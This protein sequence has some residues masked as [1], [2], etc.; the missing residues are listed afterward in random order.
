DVI[1]EDITF[2]NTTAGFRIKTNNDRSGNDQEGTNGAVKNIICRNATMTGVPG[3]I[4]ITSWYDDDVQDPSTVST[5]SAITATTPEFCNIT[6]QNIT[7]DAVE[8]KT[9]WKHNS[10]IYIYGRPEMKI[11]DI[12]FDNV[13]IESKRGMFLAYYDGLNFINN[14]SVNATSGVAPV[15]TNYGEGTITG[16]YVA[17]N[18]T[19]VTTTK[20][21]EVGRTYT[22]AKPT[23]YTTSSTGA[24]TFA[25]SNDAVAT[26][27]ATTGEITAVAA[28]TATI[29]ISQAADATYNSGTADITVT[30]NPAV[31]T[32]T[33]TIFDAADEGW[34]A[35]GVNLTTGTTT[36]NGVTWYGRSGAEM[37]SNNLEFSDKVSW[38]KYLKTGGSSTFKSGSDLAGV[39][40]YTPTKAGKIRVY[41]KGGG[42][43]ER[44]LY[45]SQSITSTNRDAT[46]AIG[47]SVTGT[48]S[49]VGIAT[50]D[51]EA[52]KPVYIWATNSML[53]Y[54]ITFES[55]VEPTHT[56]DF[57][58]WS[59]ATKTQVLG[60]T[61]GWT[62]DEGA[63]DN[64]KYITGDQIR[65]A[66][67][68][69]VDADGNLTAGGQVIKELEGLHHTGVD[70]Y[71]LGLAFDYQNLLDGN[72]NNGWGPY[73]GGS[74]L[75]VMGNSTTITIPNVKKGS[76][77][78]IGVESHKYLPAD[79]ATSEA[80]GFQVLVGGTEVGETQ[81]T[82]EYTE[83]SYD[84]SGTSGVVD[85]VLK[86]TKGCHLYWIDAEQGE[87]EEPTPAPSYP[88]TATWDFKN[89]V[90]STITGV[91][92]QGKTEDVASDKD[93]INLA[94]DATVTDGKLQ[95]NASGYAQFNNGTIIHV[96]VTS[97]YDEINVVAFPGQNK[98]TIGG[99]AAAESQSYN[100]SDAEVTQEFVEIKATGGAY[101]YSI[102]VTQQ[103]AGYVPTVD[104]DPTWDSTNNR[105][106]VK[107]S[108]NADAAV[109][110][111]ENAKGLTEALKYIASQTNKTLYIPNGTYDLGTKAQTAVPA[112]ATLKGE[113]MEG[114]IIKNNP[115]Y[116]GIGITATLQID[117]DN[118][119]LED[120]TLYCRA[121]YG[122]TLK[123]GNPTSSNA[124]RG[125]CLVDRGTNN[126]FRHI[127]LDGLQDTYYSWKSNAANTSY[128]YDCVLKGSVD[129][130]CGS[131][132]V[133]FENCTLGVVPGHS[134][135]NG[136]L[137]KNAPYII[138]PN[139]DNPD[140]G[141]IF[142]NCTIVNGSS[143]NMDGN[144][145][146]GRPW[147]AHPKASFIN[148][149]MKILPK[150]DGFSMQSAGTGGYVASEWTEI[151]S[152]DGLGNPVN[153]NSRMSDVTV[154][155][156][157]KPEAQKLPAPEV[158]KSGSKITWTAVDGA[159]AYNV[160]KDGV[161][162]AKIDVPTSSAAKGMF[163]TLAAAASP[164]EYDITGAEDATWTVRAINAL[165]VIGLAQGEEPEVVDP[166]EDITFSDEAQVIKYTNKPFAYATANDR[167]NPAS[168]SA[169][170]ITGGGEYDLETIMQK[171]EADGGYTAGTTKQI[172]TSNGTKKAIVLRSA[173]T[174][175]TVDDKKKETRVPMDDA[176]FNAIKAN[177][178]IV[179]DGSG[180]ST[181]FV[182]SKYIQLSR[183]K[184]K[185]IVGINGARLCT[186]WY[187][188]DYFKSLLE[189]VPTSSG[190]G[191]NS[192]ST[193]SGGGALEIIKNGSPYVDN[194]PEEGEYLTR[195]TLLE[196]TG[197]KTEA[198]RNAGIFYIDHSSN[199][200]IRNFKFIGPGS[201]DCAG[202]D[203][204]AIIDDT[205]HCWV[206]HCEF[207]DGMDGNFDITNRSD[208]VT[209]SWCQFRYTERSYAHQNTNL[210]G[211]SDDKTDDRN[212]LN[213][214]FA[215]NE[216][217]ANCRARMPMARFGRIHMLNNYYNCAG[218]SEYA[219]N[220]RKESQFLVEGNYWEKG[221]RR[222]Y[223]PN[224]QTAVTWGDNNFY[225]DKAA[226]KAGE[227]TGST[228]TVP[229]QY[230][231][232]MLDPM[233]V[234]EV[235]TLNGGA[236]LYQKP[237]FTTNLGVVD[238]DKTAPY[239][240]TAVLSEC[241]DDGL[242]FSVWA[243]N[244]HTFQWYKQDIALDGTPGEWEMIE[245]ENRNTYTYM[246]KTGVTFNIKCKAFGV[247][248][249]TESDEL[250]VVV[251]GESKPI[252]ITDLDDTK[253]VEVISGSPKILT[254]NAGTNG[255]TYQ[256]YKSAN[257]D[258]SSATVI[259][260][261]TD[262]SYTYKSTAT[263]GEVVY[264]FCRATNQQ[265]YTDS[266]IV[267][268]KGIY[269]NVKFHMYATYDA[270]VVNSNGTTG[271]SS[272]FVDGGTSNINNVNS[273]TANITD[274]G[275]G[276][277]ATTSN[278]ND[279]SGLRFENAEGSTHTPIINVHVHFTPTTPVAIDD[280]IEIKMN[281][282][283]VSAPDNK[284]GF[285]LS[286]SA[287]IT[288]DEDANILQKIGIPTSVGKGLHTYTYTA[289]EAL[290]TFY[291][292]PFVD[293]TKKNINLANVVV[294][295]GET[296]KPID[297]PM[298][299]KNLDASYEVSQDGTLE[300]EVDYDDN[301]VSAVQWYK[302]NSNVAA[303]GTII[304]GEKGKKYSVPTS[305][306]GMT[307]YY[308]VI[309][310]KA[311]YNETKVASVSTK[312]VV[313]AKPAGTKVYTYDMGKYPGAT[314]SEQSS[315]T[316]ATADI[317]SLED[318]DGHKASMQTKST[319]QTKYKLEDKTFGDGFK[320]T[321]Y[322]RFDGGTANSGNYVK[323][324][325]D[326]DDSY[327]S[328]Y[329]K[330]ANTSRSAIVFT[331]LQSIPTE[332]DHSKALLFVPLGGASG[333]ID[334]YGTTEALK[335][336]T[337]YVGVTNSSYIYGIV[338]KEPADATAP[339]DIVH[340]K[341]ANDASLTKNTEY[342]A[343]LG[344][345]VFGNVS[346]TKV[347]PAEGDPF[348]GNKLDGDASATGTKYA[349]II[350][351]EGMPVKEGDIIKISG[352]QDKAET[353][354]GYGFSIYPTRAEGMT[355]AKAL[356][357][358]KTKNTLED[359]E[360]KV[361]SGSS[362]IDKTEFFVFREGNTVYLTE[363]TI[364][365]EMK[366]ETECSKPIAKKTTWNATA[367]ETWNYTISSST[368]TAVI[369]YQ[370]GSGEEVVASVAPKNSVNVALKPG[371]TVKAWATDS[372]SKIDDSEVNEFTVAAKPQTAKPTITVALYSIAKKG[373]DVTISGAAAGAKVYYT[374]DGT[375]PTDASTL[376][377]GVFTSP[378]DMTIKAIAIEDHYNNSDIA[379]ANIAKFDVAG[380]EDINV[381][382][383][384]A[385]NE[386]NVGV[387]Y[388]V[389]G[390]EYNAG[391]IETK[392]PTSGIKF[393]VN[394]TLAD[395][396]GKK[397]LGF[398]IKVNDGFVIN[399]IEAVDAY[400][401]AKESDKKGSATVKAAYVDVT[402][403]NYAGATSVLVKDNLTLPYSDKT[404]S[405]EL[406]TK[407]NINARTQVDFVCELSEGA[408]V[409]QAGILFKVYYEVIDAP[410]SV[411]INGA[412][413]SDT[414]YTTLT[415]AD[416]TVVLTK[417]YNGT[418]TIIMNTEKGY[419]HPMVNV[420]SDDAYRKYQ[421]TIMGT[422]YTV[423]AMVES[424]EAPF[425]TIAEEVSLAGGYKVTV[426]P[427]PTQNTVAMISID[428]GEY[429]VYD[430]KKTYYA[431]KT[432]D[433]KT[434]Y[435]KDEVEKFTDVRSLN[436]PTNS[437]TAG[438]P[439]A[440]YL[441]VNGYS[442]NQVGSHAYN[443]ESFK[444][445][446]IYS[447]IANQFNVIPLAV[448]NS[449][450]ILE[451][452]SDITDA[453]LVVI[454]E[455]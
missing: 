82:K 427:D 186:E 363:I 164:L 306:M 325:L 4:K 148:T 9:S 51:V 166:Y 119:T 356:S 27:N 151:G 54:G 425:A 335:K 354:S 419:E 413:L 281:T 383:G 215:Y 270:N 122:T 394:R 8:G 207:V 199:L 157:S 286:K 318:P 59:A 436:C 244:A 10:P 184:D 223:N 158:T 380:T 23:D 276:C 294:Y 449:D 371:D 108:N 269:R 247:S 411:T 424:I 284:Y 196:A 5:P 154:I 24:V 117:G 376:Y 93:G 83:F 155:S 2:T 265:G 311:P 241:E 315:A 19:A 387:S 369:H 272:V 167:T 217:G 111:T 1:Y 282:S 6:F 240:Y 291:L 135:N 112:G 401:N 348:S 289:T 358:T 203:L 212:K 341:I 406:M 434:K 343:E 128:F 323:V 292:I 210:V 213:I 78:K 253:T 342:E 400:T 248:G 300:L 359:L 397:T 238:T 174:V 252:Y 43:T 237:Y 133:W 228:V 236:K 302:T 49:G 180:T 382:H 25:S 201:L 194:I 136:T 279:I 88:I 390:S 35:D 56:W 334:G 329:A 124:E 321:G 384:S 257:A 346:I 175:E 396:A 301:D 145:Y 393:R 360:Y 31:E 138:A 139:A 296:T 185:T 65:W 442:D 405:K 308:A 66:N 159:I 345:I 322:I 446:K 278:T 76:K 70:Q 420:V 47:T 416:K 357:I 46:T 226:D 97:K 377:N 132:N 437:Y 349:K 114:V 64:K 102:S 86:A 235:L 90:P 439:F 115:E 171:M 327:I 261:A 280:K 179:L 268:V 309:T 192:A 287:T 450:A 297:A 262:R 275:D 273:Q 187:L 118:V 388:F 101:L 60:D 147:N 84:I 399:K 452:R 453:K 153:T 386:N 221:V 197:D 61:E 183:V 17:S 216:W 81:K 146:L 113:S 333:G 202:Y 204:M 44:Y 422:T 319:K 45:I 178:I 99:A 152:V 87:P 316:D 95:Y 303:D 32:E 116:E 256:W 299:T 131:G 52:N 109:K 36:V 224:G 255:V 407:D 433:T 18:L 245:G 96:P 385:S 144:Y 225:A 161:F 243:E 190:T 208:F 140:Y 71:K 266:K 214:T 233:K 106:V 340:Y 14:C 16:T 68:N 72:Q 11:H 57:T 42:D 110:A 67:A 239:E 350:M 395:V 160:Y 336:G 373:F 402:D 326:K 352:F 250:K 441:Y 91:N 12:T 313:K 141:Y 143:V 372:Q 150:A 219:M 123:D 298:F 222:A 288:G 74:Y 448:N 100:P 168:V 351:P 347:T 176:I 304:A 34:T 421:C 379:S 409:N 227:N 328:V 7:A 172:S 353:P 134:D 231:A 403:G 423:K 3:P 412:K 324:V 170:N 365:R 430:A 249:E 362:L 230:S 455:T 317:P 263:T 344:K 89:G 58:N 209:V 310:G 98:Y 105:W 398:R 211:S 361:P 295:S 126:I 165:R 374:T 37:K 85:V 182:V 418:P 444:T 367:D 293:G 258:G 73:H 330:G 312:V 26:V 94:V 220:P 242:V 55:V 120:L 432:V 440:V 53:V 33:V 129:F 339:K 198:Y 20:Q 447:A 435:T 162:Q 443:N 415:G 181:D 451:K 127:T 177:D 307:Y 38:T 378:G 232:L 104:W 206:D 189:N 283:S 338:V 260:G 431:L 234:P 389:L 22:L 40:T 417:E 366:A 428:G 368:P 392:D 314:A 121:P 370:V 251:D 337:Y 331:D 277:K 191:V 103:G 426:T 274:D 15:A 218:N 39:L 246:P 205:H 414:D 429:E 254:V 130:L 267:K 305:E 149:T 48:S 28:G 271:K 200:I 285:Y 163:R 69:N 41:A 30:V 50:A 195:K 173:N 92:I 193:T 320:S 75:W 188:T 62:K 77:L 332:A 445:D 169:S 79:D 21:I 404:H 391:G 264:L 229:Y 137:S 13:Q 107:T 125:V 408:S 63:A 375:A 381:A 410:K 290:E 80:R 29:T 364:T 142:N 438:K 355:K 259:S 454:T 156:K